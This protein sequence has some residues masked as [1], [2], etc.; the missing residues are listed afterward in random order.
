MKVAGFKLADL[1]EYVPEWNGNREDSR[2][3]RVFWR[4]LGYAS[5][6]VI[7][8][9]RTI[10]TVRTDAAHGETV[11]KASFSTVD[12]MRNVVAEAV[13]RVENLTIGDREITT[14]AELAA[15]VG[16]RSVI[17]PAEF[18]ELLTEIAGIVIE[19]SSLAPDKRKKS[20]GSLG[21]SHGSGQAN[22]DATDATTRSGPPAIAEAGSVM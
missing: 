4:P 18:G 22:T 2:P 7:E 15:V 6:H 20:G 19:G 14:G 16:D 8:S 13:E 1:R 10:R 17:V 12:M 9:A 21:S 5:V 11:V 3:M